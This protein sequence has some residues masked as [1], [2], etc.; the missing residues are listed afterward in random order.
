[1]ILTCEAIRH[2]VIAGDITIEPFDCR[3]LGPNSYDFRLG[4]SCKVYKDHLLDTARQNPTEDLT[5][6]ETGIVLRPNRIYLFNTVE[7]IGSKVFVPIIRGRSSTGRLGLFVHI[8]ADLIDLGSI[9]QLTLQL[10]S[11]AP[12][13]VYPGMLIG[14]ATFWKVQGPKSFYNGKYKS[15]SSP[16]PS[17][18]YLDWR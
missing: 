4:A 11:V 14:Q 12:L 5:V 7:R 15:L 8:T 3:Q 10:H 2:A 16:S 1:M 9:N 17:L 18:S 6:D 13:R